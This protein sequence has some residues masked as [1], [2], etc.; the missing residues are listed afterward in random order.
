LNEILHHWRTFVGTW[1]SK[2]PFQ[3]PQNHCETGLVFAR[4]EIGDGATG[5][6]VQ[7]GRSKMLMKE[8]ICDSFE[9]CDERRN[10]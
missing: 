7:Q 10:L 2:I 1:G 8:E 3:N 9:I 6:M 5:K 4:L